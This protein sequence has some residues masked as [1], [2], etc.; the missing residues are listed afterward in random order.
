MRDFT[1]VQDVVEANLLALRQDANPGEVFN[2]AGGG[3]T[4]INQLATLLAK[5]MGKPQ[6]LPEY[7]AERPGDVRGSHADI[8]KAKEIL[9]YEPKFVPAQGLPAVV[10]W[11]SR[12]GALMANEPNPA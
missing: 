11:F 5:L 6:I 10:K 2:I 8:S 9:R 12:Y 4:S 7:A 1:Y 3:T